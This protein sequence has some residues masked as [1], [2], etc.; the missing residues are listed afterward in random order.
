MGEQT[1]T[2]D[3]KSPATV[4]RRRFM[5]TAAAAAGVTI[6][7]RHVLGGTGIQA[8]SDTVNVAV[9]G[10][11]HG[12]GTSNLENVART[13]NIVAL[14]DCDES[15]D[16]KASLARHKTLEKCPK[17]KQYKDFRVMLE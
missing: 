5:G 9:V 8:P 14:C 10:Y 6:V 17:A 7:P 15:D 1:M 13:D 11:I 4:S 3:S 12:K 2:R 16:G